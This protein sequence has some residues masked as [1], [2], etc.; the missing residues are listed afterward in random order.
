MKRRLLFSLIGAIIIFGW[1]FLSFAFPNFHKSASS[2]TP[3]QDEILL[4]LQEL[5]LKEGMYFLG[6]PDPSL[7]MDEQK[8]AMDSM[9]GKPWAMINYHLTNSM[10]MALNMITGFVVCFIISFLLF[11]VFVQQ[12]DPVLKNRI[13]LSLA[14]G[15]IGFLFTPYIKFIWYREPDIFAY[16]ADGIIPWILLGIVG[17]KMVKVQEN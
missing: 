6:Q 9:E 10:S 3:A 1:Q 12:K 14:V 13:F 2:Y 4:K 5:G 7:S 11:W 16:F 15:I 8:T 17:H